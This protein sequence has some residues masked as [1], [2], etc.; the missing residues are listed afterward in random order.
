MLERPASDFEIQMYAESKNKVYLYSRFEFL[1]NHFGIRPKAL[2]G[3][4]ACTGS[5]KSTL[6]K[7]IV[8]EAARQTKVLIWLSEESKVQYQAMINY[9]DKDCIKNISFVEEKKIPKEFKAS[10]ELF[11]EYF[12]QMQEESG[13]GL[14]FIDNVTTSEFY[15]QKFGMGGQENS[16]DFLINFANTKASVF[17]VAHTGSHVTENYGKV[18]NPE[19]IRGSKK[20]AFETEYC[21]MVQKFVSNGNQYNILRVSKF[22]HHKEA[23]GWYALKFERDAY[24]AAPKVPFEIVNKIFQSRDYFGKKLPKKKD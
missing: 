10:Q 17:Y 12:E 2:H 24:V 1:M 23:A 22:R 6:M 11:F 18:A 21:Y 5:G 3:M 13:A 14:V 7:C 8:A 15:S 4:I 19:D 16:A 20:L 9:L